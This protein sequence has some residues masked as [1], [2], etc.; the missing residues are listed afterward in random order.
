MFVNKEPLLESDNFVKD[1]E[2]ELRYVYN[3]LDTSL[4]SESLRNAKKKLKSLKMEVLNSNIPKL[5]SFYKETVKKLEY[6]ERT[7]IENRAD[8]TNSNLTDEDLT[9]LYADTL[10][11]ED[12]KLQESQVESNERVMNIKHQTDIIIDMSVEVNNTVRDQGKKI[13][14]LFKKMKDTS[15]VKDKTN[16]VLLELKERRTRLGIC[17]KFVVYLASLSFALFFLMMMLK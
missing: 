6:N 15:E 9:E 16:R 7:P 17:F 11:L 5:Y 10:T 4:D 12:I 8:R 1:I 3:S 2:S 14:G 13:D